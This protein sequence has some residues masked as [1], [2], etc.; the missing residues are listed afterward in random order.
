MRAEDFHLITEL[1]TEGVPN[2]LNI[3]EPTY[4]TFPLLLAVELRKIK[5]INKLFSLGC[6]ANICDINGNASIY[7][8]F[9]K[10]YF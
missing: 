3:C 4:G 6:N 1:V 9:K 7:Q 8:E 2:L 10:K 5:V